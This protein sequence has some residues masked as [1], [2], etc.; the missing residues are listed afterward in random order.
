MKVCPA[1]SV[2][3]QEQPT[4]RSARAQTLADKVFPLRNTDPDGQALRAPAPEAQTSAAS[5]PSLG[6]PGRAV[7]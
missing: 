2:P 4:A 3:L 1:V 7:S 5:V 6:A